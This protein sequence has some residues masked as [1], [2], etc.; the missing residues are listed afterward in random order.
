[1]CMQFYFNKI[2]S[3]MFLFTACMLL[4]F[5]PIRKTINSASPGARLYTT[6]STQQTLYEYKKLVCMLAASA[7]YM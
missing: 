6:G 4:L 5:I 3:K 7:E 1:M 2:P